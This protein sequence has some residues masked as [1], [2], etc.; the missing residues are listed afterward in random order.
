MFS[1]AELQK[2]QSEAELR[3]VLEQLPW[4]VSNENGGPPAESLNVVIIGALDDPFAPRNDRYQALNSRYVF[5]WAQDILSN[6]FQTVS[7]SN[8]GNFSWLY[9]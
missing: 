2:V 1:P 7:K 6:P 4:C 3:Q 5:K 8:L 9:T